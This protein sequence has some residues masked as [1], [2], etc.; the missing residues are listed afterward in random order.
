MCEQY[1]VFHVKLFPP[2]VIDA[3]ALQ[4]ET[5]VPLLRLPCGTFTKTETT[6]KMTIGNDAKPSHTSDDVIFGEDY[7][8]LYLAT[9]K[10]ALGTNIHPRVSCGGAPNVLM[11]YPHEHCSR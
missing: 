5:Y 7:R 9:A 6:A 8:R 4:R 3:V 2:Y 10:V 11:R 1:P